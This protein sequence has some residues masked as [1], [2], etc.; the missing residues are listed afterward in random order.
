MERSFDRLKWHRVREINSNQASFYRCKNKAF[1]FKYPFS[2]GYRVK[3]VNGIIKVSPFDRLLKEKEI[4]DSKLTTKMI[5]A[6]RGSE[7]ILETSVY[8]YLL[9]TL[10]AEFPNGKM[11]V[12]KAL[13]ISS[14]V[15]LKSNRHRDRPICD[16]T[17]CQVYYP[18]A[19]LPKAKKKRIH[20]ALLRVF[21]SSGWTEFKKLEWMPFY[22]GGTKSWSK[23][24]EGKFLLK[25]LGL[26]ESA[27]KIDVEQKKVQLALNNQTSRSFSC[28]YF[29]N[30][31]NLFSCPSTVSL[32]GKNVWLASGNG[33]GH[34]IGMDL[35]KANLMASRGQ[36]YED[37]LKFFYP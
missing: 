37:I 25:R 17:H 2:K 18:F 31:L 10:A 11:E 24:L 3:S 6:R 34:G 8:N 29:R 1:K 27:V 32:I 9:N 22:L 33:E 7:F 30:Q 16:T 13:A 21:S 12:L 19:A 5:R 26:S 36:K 35:T 15:N 23:R 14:Y 4:N 20:K 28:E